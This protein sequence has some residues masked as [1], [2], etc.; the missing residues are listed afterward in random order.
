MK[1]RMWW[2]TPNG[3]ARLKRTVVA[4][5]GALLLL[6]S[7]AAAQVTVVN[8]F[9][10]NR[11]PGYRK[12]YPDA[13]GAVGPKHTAVLDD[14]AFV[15]QDKATGKV[16]QNDTQHDFWFKVLPAGT[17]DIQANDPRLLYD[18]ITE[19]WIAW[20]QG[21][22]PANGYLAV[23]TTSDPTKLWRGVKMPIPPHN[24][25][26]RI[27][28]DKNGL[29]ISVH[30]GSNDLKKAQTCYAIPMADVVAADGPN[31]AHMQ[32]FPDLQIES[33]PATDLD[34]KKAPEAP[35]VLLNRE[36]GDTASKLYL[37]KITWSG[38]KA[39][40]SNAQSIPLSKTYPS[41]NGSSKKFQAVQPAPGL[42]LRADEGRRTLSVFANG[43]SVFGCN[44]AKRKLDSRCGI[45]W[46]EV[47]VSDGVLLQEGFV[48]APDCDYL[49]PTLAVDSKGNVGL[50]CTRT[51]EKEFPSVYVMMHAATD[52]PGTMRAP[53]LAVKGTTYFRSPPSGSTNAIGWGNYSSTCID[54]LDPT[55]I[56]TCQEYANSTVEREWC[57]AWTAFRF[58]ENKKTP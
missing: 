47:R 5:L 40:I 17:F 31:L 37:Y 26:A 1:R 25:G 16:I 52:A 18:P 36:F 58:N 13:A 23:S 27:G 42:N 15:A 7:V 8:H 28:F 35:A 57:T 20:V 30:N 14:R 56:W 50:G 45:L 49:V 34:A 38:K 22:M 19:R 46:Y 32:A 2:L 4:S 33:F 6:Q 3:G 21:L 9:A 43:G 24:Y 12:P 10:A 53:E 41:P 48:D 54:P 44:A 39:T 55:L 51:S 11:G 29:Y